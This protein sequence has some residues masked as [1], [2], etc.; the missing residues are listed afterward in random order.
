[1]NCKQ[2]FIAARA[3][4][5]EMVKGAWWPDF[6]YIA[7]HHPKLRGPLDFSLGET[8]EGEVRLRVIGEAS[9]RKARGV[10][11]VTLLEIGK[12]DQ[13]SQIETNR[14]FSMLYGL[15]GKPKYSCP[16]LLIRALLLEVEA[17]V[18]VVESWALR[19]GVID[20]VSL[21]A[22]FSRRYYGVFQKHIRLAYA[23]DYQLP[24]HS[25]LRTCAKW[26]ASKW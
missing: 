17:R 6:A 26:R 14:A 2:K 1:M 12:G 19:F 4:F 21:S 18:G 8:Q 20:L 10:K 9:A 11:T 25:L 15:H 5:R 7:V 16:S 13:W 23:Y 3:M 22:D 24:T